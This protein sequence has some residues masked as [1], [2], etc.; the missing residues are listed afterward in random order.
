MVVRRTLGYLARIVAIR[1]DKPELLK[2]QLTALSR[3]IP[4]LYFIL[5]ANAWVLSITF[6]G[7]APDWLALYVAL[8]LSVVC[9]LRLALWWPK[10][11]AILSNRKC[12]RELMHTNVFAA[13][14]GIGFSLW[15]LSLFPYGGTYEKAHVGLFLTITTL[16]SMLCLIHLRSAALLVAVTV[17]VPFVLYFVSTGVPAFVGM[18]INVTLVTIAAVIVILFQYRDF[19]RMVQARTRTETLSNEN[20]RLANVDSLT[21]LPNRRAFFTY[22]DAAFCTAQ[23]RGARLALGIIDLNGFKAVNDLYGHAV[24]D[25]LLVQ[26]ASRLSGIHASNGASFLSRLGGDEFAYAVADAPDNEALVVRAEEIVSLLRK[27]FVLA[28]AIVQISGSIG[29]TVYPEMA[30]SAEQLFERTDY[31]LYH[32]KHERRGRAVLFSSDHEAQINSEAR[33]EQ[34]LKLAD[35]AQELTVAFQP[36]FDIRSQATIGFEALARWSSPSLGRISPAQF[37]PIAERTG[38]IS[39][40]TRPLLEK[41][42]LE[43]GKWPDDVRLSFNLSAHDLGS[44][45]NLAAI[46]GIIEGSGFD[47]GR[48]DLEITETAFTHDFEQVHQS[49]DRLRRLGCGIS[50]DDFGT[51]YSS[52]SR[53]HALPLTRIKIDRSFVTGLHKNPASLKIVKSL[54]VLSR[55]M[56]L[57]CVVEGV[58]TREEMAALRELGAVMAQGYFYSPPIA[59]NDVLSFLH[60]QTMPL[61]QAG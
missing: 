60:D 43:A 51:G 9:G 18:A 41:A 13:L 19:T 47:P 38:I 2:A 59:Q 30:S 48:L 53:L 16:G 35:F 49:V 34:A 52:L 61:L 6:V 1:S 32:G 7:L 20:L 31:A 42:L 58:E 5:V 14:L 46:V 50:L 29:I 12:V 40:L 17:A 4:L 8:A 3:M 26:V 37:V 25:K 33:I 27:P 44:P 23:S 36:I 54:L 21:G 11:G 22:L 28:E 24:G 57:D 39:A 15:A 45:D 55:D 10:K 56:G